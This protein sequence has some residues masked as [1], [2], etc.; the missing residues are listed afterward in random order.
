MLLMSLLD[1]DFQSA[2]HREINTK[3][4]SDEE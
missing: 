1:T 4:S 2:S 3:C